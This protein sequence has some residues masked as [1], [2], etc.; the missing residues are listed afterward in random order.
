MI[1]NIAVLVA[2]GVATLFGLVLAAPPA[3][4]AWYSSGYW[5]GA[6]AAAARNLKAPGLSPTKEAAPSSRGSKH[7]PAEDNV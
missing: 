3:G 7:A 1:P 6:R 5:D 4:A 2:G